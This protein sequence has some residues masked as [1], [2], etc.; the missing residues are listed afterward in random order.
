VNQPREA[1]IGATSPTRFRRWPAVSRVWSRAGLAL[2]V[3]I[4]LAL[5]LRVGAY[6]ESPR[7]FEGAGLAAA[8]AEMARNIVDHGR[9]F[10]VNPKATKLLT[11]RQIKL[12][13]LVDPKELD[14]G[15]F[16]RSTRTEPEI[17][18]MPGVALVLAALWWPTGNE[19][20]ASLQWLQLLVD[21]AMVLLIYWIGIR[22]TR[23][24][25]VSLLAGL[26]YA[27]WPGAI[28]MDPRPVLDTW[29]IFFTIGCVAAFLWAR[30]RPSSRWRLIS[31]GVLTGFGVYFRPFLLFL[32]I[33]LAAVATPGGGWKRRLLWIATPTA[34]AL[35][36]LAP[37]TVRNY[38][39]FHRFI[40]TRTGLGQ[41]VFQGAGLAHGD[42]N[43]AK[44]VRGH[45]K[46][47][48][49]GSPKYDG[50]LLGAAVRDIAD[51]PGPYIRK[52]AHRARFLLPCLLV[53]L[54]WRR[55]GRNALVPVAAAAATIVP[56]LLIG[57]DTRFYLPAA[58]AYCI[59]VA[60]AAVGVSGLLR[61]TIPRVTARIRG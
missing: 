7:P 57:D 30:E 28:V 48:T 13:R 44:Y 45:A 33:A 24:V 3:I 6:L 8:Q 60:M 18:Q 10:V 32:P 29:A 37:W 1:T 40:P 52:V 58:F 4:A 31:L 12:N 54:V 53:L 11:N 21:T 23:N 9:W 41:A 56:Y 43:S 20:Y 38:Y 39:E 35:L 26:L 42:E 16:D 51:H 55:W 5:A 15:Q 17:D 22:L 61:G 49:Y 25:Y 50:V 2:G 46:D 14:L 59:L 47:A 34:V 19:T 27:I 36:V